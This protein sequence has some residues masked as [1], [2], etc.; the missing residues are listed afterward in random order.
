MSVFRCFILN[1]INEKIVIVYL[2]FS[3]V[4]GQWSHWSE[5]LHCDAS[6][7]GGKEVRYRNCTNP[8][9]GVNGYP[10]SGSSI[11]SKV[12]NSFT[13]P[14]CPHRP[15][16][17]GVRMHCETIEDVTSCNATCREGLTFVPGYP[18]LKE[19]E[20]GQKTN[21]TWSG[22]P[23]S[24]S[25]LNSP[26]KMEIHSAISFTNF[27]CD[28]VHHAKSQ[29]YSNA[30]SGLQC[31][32][33]D[34][35]EI[36]ID[37]KGCGSREKRSTGVEAV[38]TLS[39]SLD[40]GDNLDLDKYMANETISPALVNV[41]KAIAELENSA[42]EINRTGQVFQIPGV[43]IDIGQVKVTSDIICSPGKIR[44]AAFCV[45]C[46]AGTFENSNAIC[47]PCNFGMYQNLLGQTLCKSCADGYTTAIVGA[48]DISLCTG[49][50][51]SKGW[52]VA[53]AVV[54]LIV[55]VLML[56]GGLIVRKQRRIKYRKQTMG[57]NFSFNMVNQSRQ[58]A[59]KPMNFV[60]RP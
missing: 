8:A 5:W 33:N 21:Y 15:S 54:I 35:C 45:D 43:K 26:S 41:I 4:D 20:C 37:I 34:T 12:C 60:Q 13:C 7:G 10:C 22:H 14:T 1:Y 18:A 23:P 6:C 59:V 58:D 36:L 17:Y 57:S 48:Q 53:V 31:G 11:E 52:I 16:A 50:S 39:I 56:V 42:F 3:K 29:I 19:Y 44:I 25:R 55:V 47:K 51:G 32:R 9:P 24:C 27:P 2:T 40:Q 49:K 38:L 30:K 46:P 28:D